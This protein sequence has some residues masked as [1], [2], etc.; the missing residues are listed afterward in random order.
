[1]HRKNA[2]QAMPSGG[3]LSVFLEAT[4][5]DAPRPATLAP[6]AAADY[7]VLS[8]ADSGTGIPPEIID[9]IFDPFFT[10]KEVGVGTGLGL[11]L[12]HGIVTDLGGAIDVAS[13]PGVGSKFTVYLPRAGDAAEGPEADQPEMPRG[14][15]ER[16][17]VVDDEKPL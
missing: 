4:Y 5:Y 9:R 6:V 14:N 3:S 1:M 11:S 7:I 15:G 8:V 17:P 13:K 16:V 10:T 12:L 2:V